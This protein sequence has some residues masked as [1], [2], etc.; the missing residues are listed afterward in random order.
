MKASSQNGLHKVYNERRILYFSPEQVFDV[1]S[2]VEN[3]KCFVP[4]CKKS[5]ILER[6]SDSEFR[7]RLHVGFKLLSESYDSFVRVK[8][9]DAVEVNSDSS[10]MFKHLTNSWKLSPGPFEN[11]TIV[12]FN[13]SF[14]FASVLHSKIANIFFDE[15]VKLN[16]LAFEKRC[17]KVY[18]S[19]GR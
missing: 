10:H 2:N 18:G 8:R 17:K 13:V 19:G 9:P 6:I 12:E 7:A 3:Y 14:E 15:V 1:V 5:E 4:W 11:S 16:V